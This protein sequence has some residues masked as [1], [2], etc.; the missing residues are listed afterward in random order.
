MEL[1]R[2]RADAPPGDGAMVEL[3]DGRAGRR[4]HQEHLVGT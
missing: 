2:D 1:L 4:A 3:D